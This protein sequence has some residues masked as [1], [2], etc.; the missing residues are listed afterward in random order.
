MELS[1]FKNTHRAQSI[2]LVVSREALFQFRNT[3]TAGEAI[4]SQGK[5]QRLEIIYSVGERERKMGR[6]EIIQMG[7]GV[8][9]GIARSLTLTL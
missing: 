1:H 2:S 5:E 6:M 9:A 4:H 8:A 3:V 7:G